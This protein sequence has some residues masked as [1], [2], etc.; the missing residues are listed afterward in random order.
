M[1]T[2]VS[3]KRAAPSEQPAFFFQGVEE[4]FRDTKAFTLIELRVAIAVI[5]LLMFVIVPAS[6]FRD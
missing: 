2:I 5:G 4:R 6:A 1:D 3:A